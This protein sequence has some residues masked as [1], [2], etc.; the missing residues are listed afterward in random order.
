MYEAQRQDKGRP[1]SGKIAGTGKENCSERIEN[2]PVCKTHDEKQQ[3]D[4]VICTDCGIDIEAAGQDVQHVG[5]RA[6]CEDCWWERH[7]EEERNAI[8]ERRFQDNLVYGM[9]LEIAG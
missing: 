3:C 9:S 7:E 5:K 6:F 1:V 8:E 4:T 2:G